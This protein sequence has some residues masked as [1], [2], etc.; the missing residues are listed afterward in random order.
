MK[1]RRRRHKKHHGKITKAQAKRM[2][3]LADQVLKSLRK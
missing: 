1:H 3:K 2:K